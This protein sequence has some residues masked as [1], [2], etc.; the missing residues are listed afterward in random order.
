MPV[1]TIN[2]WH[3]RQFEPRLCRRAQGTNNIIVYTAKSGRGHF[4]PIC[5]FRAA[6]GAGKARI[7]I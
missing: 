7:T 1:G 4:S 2:L 3:A 5:S 6:L